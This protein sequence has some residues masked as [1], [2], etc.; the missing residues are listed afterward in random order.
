M[1][2]NDGETMKRLFVTV[3]AM[4]VLSGCAAMRGVGGDQTGERPAPLQAAPAAGPT[5]ADGIERVPFRAGVST[6]TVENMG[7]QAGC[8]GTQG[9][10]LMTPPG[11]VEVYRLVCDNGAVF[12]AK[13]ELRQ[14][15]RMPLP[16]RPPAEAVPARP[17]AA[18]G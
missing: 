4:A 11:P 18:Q 8:R 7:K 9:A 13:C 1:Q 15:K 17:P 12:M 16:I 2:F 3:M 6:V 10:G 5:D 14:C